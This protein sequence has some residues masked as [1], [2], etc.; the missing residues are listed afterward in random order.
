MKSFLS[1]SLLWSAVVMGIYGLVL[2][3]EAEA[4][5]PDAVLPCAIP[6]SVDVVCEERR[7]GVVRWLECRDRDGNTFD[8]IRGDRA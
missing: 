4:S 6:P 3:A 5:T 1:L 7:I 8:L 2:I